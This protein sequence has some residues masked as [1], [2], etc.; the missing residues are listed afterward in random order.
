VASQLSAAHDRDRE[1]ARSASMCIVS[2]LHYLCKQGL[3]IRGHTETTGNFDNLLK[4]RAADN[5]LLKLWL[6]RSGYKWLSPVIQN[7]IIEDLALS[8]L[9]S[10]KK[11]IC[12]AKYFAIVM[13]ETTDASC[14]EQV[15]YASAM[16]HR[17]CRSMRH[18]L[19]FMKLHRQQQVPCL[20]LLKML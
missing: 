20:K 16:F 7:E 3:A 6:D 18:S 4:L 15:I 2:S 1:V 17:A 13:D 10:L 14:R 19:D 8:V 5:S 11:D 9:R 12:D